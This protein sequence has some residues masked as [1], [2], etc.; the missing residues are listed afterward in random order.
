MPVVSIV[1]LSA[2]SPMKSPEALPAALALSVIPPFA[3]ERVD[4][5]STTTLRAVVT[6][7][8]PVPV[9]AI[10][11]LIVVV[12]VPADCVTLLPLSTET[13]GRLTFA[14][15]T[16]VSPAMF[17]APPIAPLR[18]TLPPVP[19]LMLSELL[20]AAV[21]SIV[22][23]TVTSSPAAVPAPN[24]VVIDTLELST[25]LALIETAL[26]AVRMS[27]SRVVVPALFR[28]MDASPDPVI[29]SVDAPE[30]TT[31]MTPAPLGA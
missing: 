22:P 12:P 23:V 26:A 9:V 24:V 7:I 3:V 4:P 25:T 10:F 27:A 2:S 17:S 1:T 16:I 21:S 13:L 15:L 28:V 20:A 19:P 29:P 31:L 14:A 6:L 5:A 8:V 11:P 18:S 30:S